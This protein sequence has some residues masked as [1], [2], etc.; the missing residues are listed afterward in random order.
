MRKHKT[1]KHFKI[2]LILLSKTQLH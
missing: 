2:Q 1:M